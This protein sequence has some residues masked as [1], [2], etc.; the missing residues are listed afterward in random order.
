LR[1]E[2]NRSTIDSLY[3]IIL[4][5]SGGTYISQVAAPDQKSAVR[6]WQA[7]MTDDDLKTWKLIRAEVDTLSDVPPIPLDGLENAWCASASGMNGL[8]LINIIATQP[9]TEN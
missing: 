9:P 1:H 8:I 6:V 3:S 7:K 5:Y 2:G 4:D